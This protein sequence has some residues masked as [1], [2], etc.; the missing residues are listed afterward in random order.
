MTSAPT[1]STI[2]ESDELLLVLTTCRALSAARFDTRLLDAVPLPSPT[3]GD[4]SNV[5]DHVPR[6]IM[7]GRLRST[8]R[9]NTDDVQSQLLQLSQALVTIGQIPKEQ[10]A[11]VVEQLQP[12]TSRLNRDRF[13]R[14]YGVLTIEEMASRM[15]C[16]VEEVR[17]REI[18]GDIFSARMSGLDGPRYPAFQL[19][20]N[21][22][23]ALLHQVI[24]EYHEWGA[25]MTFLWV[26]LRSPSE[27][28]DGWT[29]ME[30]LLGASIPAYEALTPSEKT[31]VFMEFVSEELS[32]VTQ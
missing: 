29:P 3:A 9:E 1:P 7:I 11:A 20:G 32:R 6:R 24:Q 27:M 31:E 26:F 4:S 21:L 10:I 30:I 16:T 12:A 15:K 14:E 28:F 22:N 18:S 23:R 5:G 19:H 13:R 8:R 17:E 2:E 25:S